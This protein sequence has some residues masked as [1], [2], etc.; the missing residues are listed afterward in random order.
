M[1]LTKSYAPL[2]RR[3]GVLR[4]AAPR[5]GRLSA[6]LSEGN[7]SGVKGLGFWA[8]FGTEMI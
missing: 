3:E 4:S 1:Y 5:M 8:L 2:S 6:S 7:N